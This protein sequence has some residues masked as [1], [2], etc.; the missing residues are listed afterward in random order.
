VARE[1]CEEIGR[2]PASLRLSLYAPDHLVAEGGQ[3]RVDLIGEYA[4]LG[5][6]R[7]VVF[8]GKGSA[9]LETQVAFAEDVRAA[10]IVLDTA[11]APAS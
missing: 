10:G 4:E 7:L 8:L 3:R 9:E 1:R 6:S 11:E 2:D 5:L